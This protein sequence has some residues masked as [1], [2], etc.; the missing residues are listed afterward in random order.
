MPLSDRSAT[1]PSIGDVHRES[2]GPSRKKADM[3]QPSTAISGHSDVTIGGSKD[4]AEVSLLSSAQDVVKGQR[5]KRSMRRWLK[6]TFALVLVA[7]F[8]LLS[9]GPASAA[10]LRQSSRAYS[11]CTMT[12]YLYTDSRGVF[13][14]AAVPCSAW[15]PS[16]SVHT[17]LQVY[18][19]SFWNPAEGNHWRNITINAWGPY[20]GYGTYGQPT[21]WSAPGKGCGT[22]RAETQMSFNNSRPTDAQWVA[23]ASVYMCA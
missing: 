11:D 13:A 9:T 8:T 22:W 20:S 10:V 1:V 21:L 16:V 14:G 17:H 23:T 18:D 3:T 19:A 5:S 15:H 6:T 2:P 4:L 7:L 12:A